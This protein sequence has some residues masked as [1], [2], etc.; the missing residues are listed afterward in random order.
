[1]PGVGIFVKTMDFKWFKAKKIFEKYKLLCKD[2]SLNFPQLIIKELEKG[3][4]F[5]Y[6]HC[7]DIHFH[8]VIFEGFLLFYA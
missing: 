7:Y 4:D 2:A 8:Q 1:M 5:P 6:S 3:V